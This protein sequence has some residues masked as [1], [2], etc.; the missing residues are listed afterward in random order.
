MSER[1][2]RARLVTALAGLILAACDR[3]A[4]SDLELMTRAE[5]RDDPGSAAEIGHW[6]HIDVGWASRM[7]T[8]SPPPEAVRVTVNDREAR[9]SPFS[10]GD[11]VW[12]LLFEAG[13]FPVEQGALTVIRVFD[14][15]ELLADASY[16]D[17]FPGYG[18]RLAS[19]GDGQ[20]RLG[21][22]LT[23]GL[24]A[25]LPAE[26]ERLTSA[27]YFWLEPPESVPPFYEHGRVTLGSDRMSLTV[28]SPAH[29]G[30]AALIVPTYFTRSSAARTCRGFSSCA[31][32]P[33][34][35]IGPVLLEVVPPPAP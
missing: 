24:L 8:C 7:M 9:P 23:L 21:E 26:V 12:D 13:P 35:T 27:Q 4:T 18:A 29:T 34:E 14:G 28:T 30:R 31:S 33:S 32:W 19:P 17:L 15:G 6:V 1:R 22:S 11:C 10:V 25:P 20:L 5:W 16:A 2:R 3:G